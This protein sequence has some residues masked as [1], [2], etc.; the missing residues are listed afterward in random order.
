MN[1]SF[2][3]ISQAL[4]STSDIEICNIAFQSTSSKSH[5]HNLPGLTYWVSR[6]KSAGFRHIFRKSLPHNNNHFIASSS[7]KHHH[8]HHYHLFQHG[9]TSGIVTVWSRR[10]GTDKLEGLHHDGRK[11]S[12]PSNNHF[13]VWKGNC[14][15]KLRGYRISQFQADANVRRDSSHS[16]AGIRRGSPSCI[17]L[18]T[19]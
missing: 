3:R 18:P 12:S 10:R 9:I 16:I 1:S 8:H 7:V 2:L 19:M 17:F 11:T 6:N 13:I 5:G 4:I 15:Q 14:L